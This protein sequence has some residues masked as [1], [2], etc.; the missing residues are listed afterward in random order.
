VATPPYTAE[1]KL[2]RDEVAFKVAVERLSTAWAT[3][4]R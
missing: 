1:G 2:S 4:S 3:P